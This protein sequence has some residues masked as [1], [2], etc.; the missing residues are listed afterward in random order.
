[1]S[2]LEVARPTLDP[3]A[4]QPFTSVEEYI[5]RCTDEIWVD[6]GVGLIDAAYYD[7]DVRIHGAFGT[8]VGLSSVIA[9]TTQSIAS[10]PDE[11]GFGEDV[12]WEPR[13]EQSFISSHRVY[14][15][16]TNTGWTS[17][18][19]PSGRHFEKRALAHCLV[20]NG[21]IIEEWVVRDEH[22]LVVDLGHDPRQVAR[23]F[24]ERGD[25]RPLELGHLPEDPLCAGVSGERDPGANAGEDQRMLEMFDQLWNDRRHD[26]ISDF[27]DRDVVL[28]TSRGRTLQGLRQVSTETLDV[29]AAFPD[30]RQRI[31]D[32][33]IDEHPRRGQRA[34]VVWLLEGTYSGYDV[35]GPA[36]GLPIQ[37]LGASQF[38]LEGGRIVRE[39]RVYDELALA[40]Q[41]E[42]G[43]LQS[44]A[45]DS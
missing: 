26:R 2:P 36:T 42:Q 33:C 34:A 28:H 14:S 5:L 43:R 25:W 16:G 45:V 18:G 24:A 15:T 29:L 30:A 37:L 10:Y 8:S 20:K 31:L 35:Y 12:V 38:V 4:H 41:I 6:R 7:P 21:K 17:Y 23:R 27:Y 13:G 44:T 3:S 40:I 32:V 9:G 1:M 19:P 39:F 22:R 11:V